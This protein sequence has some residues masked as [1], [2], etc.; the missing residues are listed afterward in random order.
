MSYIYVTEYDGD[1]EEFD[2]DAPGS[3]GAKGL[4]HR[5]RDGEEL[6]AVVLI[7][8]LLREGTHFDVRWVMT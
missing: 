2:I 1:P 4:Q 7:A 6:D 3:E 5:L 8:E